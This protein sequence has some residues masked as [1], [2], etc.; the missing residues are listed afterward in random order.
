MA[1]SFIPIDRNC[2]IELPA[3]LEGWL[4]ED[5]L[6]RFVVDV[7]EQLDLSA[8]EQAYSGRGSP[9]YPPKLMVALLFYG[10]A[11][12]VF[13]SRK[14]EQATY[15]SVPFIYIA[16]GLHPDHD[17]INSFRKRFVAQL[18]E[19]F[20]Q[21]LLIAHHLGVLKLGDIFID[22]S[23]VEANASKHKAMSWGYANKLEAHLKA[24]VEKLLDL[25]ET[26]TGQ[27]HRGLNIPA[28]L[29]RREERLKKIAEA[30]AEIE[31][32]AQ[33]RYARERGE[34]DEK[35]ARRAAKEKQTKK[36]PGGRAPK[37]PMPGPQDNDQVNFT[38]EESRIMPVSGGGFEQAYNGQIGVERDSRLIVCQHISQQPNDKQELV[39]A[40]DHLAQL[41]GELGKVETAS[42]D[43]GYYSEDN[44]SACEKAGVVPYIACGREPHYPP[45]AERLA[46]APEAP[47]NP[48]P[49]SA[50]RHRLKTAEGKAHYAKRKSTVEPVFGI[51]KHVIGFRQF[52]L[53]GLKAVQGEWTLVCIAFNLKRLHT[54]KGVKKA[55]EVA[56]NMFLSMLS[57][58][59]GAY[60]PP[61]GSLGLGGKHVPCESPTDS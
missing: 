29:A 20:V 34:Y 1:S 36:K 23:K 54:L 17:S 26:A 7:V 3:S 42:A 59:C 52:M 48:D 45:L 10:Y 37:A 32:R 14:L 47:E 6:A 30:K 57:L 2:P 38:D 61:H 49:V 53:R 46:G 9:A 27:E 21:I 28:E 55:A 25:A 41:P 22:G 4:R 5:H 18:E 11:T 50:L 58:Q 19:L 43:M 51:I 16:G 44:V 40:L 31:R 56:A 8:I 35:M 24:E 15:E 60:T 33:E 39:P 13:S 12:G